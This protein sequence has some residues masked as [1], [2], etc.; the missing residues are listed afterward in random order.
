MGGGI[1]FYAGI[2]F[3]HGD[4]CLSDWDVVCATPGA[5]QL[6]QL[7]LISFPAILIGQAAGIGAFVVGA[8]LAG[9]YLMGRF[10]RAT[11]PAP[12]TPA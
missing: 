5:H 11:P 1:G 3:L 4:P 12:A 10:Q 7:Q 9:R 6:S 2:T 8:F